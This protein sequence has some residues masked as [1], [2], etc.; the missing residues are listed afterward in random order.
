MYTTKSGS[1]SEATLLAWPLSQSN[2]ASNAGNPGSSEYKNV[3]YAE[4]YRLVYIDTD[5]NNK[6]YPI[7]DPVYTTTDNTAYNVEK[8]GVQLY[9][10]GTIYRLE[11]QKTAAT[12][13]A[14]QIAQTAP[15][16]SRIA[17]VGTADSGKIYTGSDAASAFVTDTTEVASAVDTL[18]KD[19]F[20]G[21]TIADGL[22]KAQDIFDK[23]KLNPADSRK[24][25]V[26]VFGANDTWENDNTDAT[27][28]ADATLKDK[29][30]T[31]VYTIGLFQKAPTS[32]VEQFM[33]QMSS[34]YYSTV[35]APNASYLVEDTE[36]GGKAYHYLSY[37]SVF[38][39]DA[40]SIYEVVKNVGTAVLSVTTKMHLGTSN[41]E[42][43]NAVLKDIISSNF[44]VT[45]IDYTVETAEGYYE[46]D[47]L[48][49]KEPDTLSETP[50]WDATTRTL[51]YTGFDYNANYISKERTNG[52]GQKIIVTI[53]GLK[54]KDSAA[55]KIK[56]DSDR[57]IYFNDAASGIYKTG[58]EDLVMANFPRPYVDN[59]TNLA[60]E[61]S[62]GK[63][64]NDNGVVVNK[65]LTP[66]DN[67]KYDLTVET[68]TTKSNSEYLEKVPTDFIVVADQSRSMETKDM[69]GA[70]TKA[71]TTYIETIA[72]DSKQENP[73]GYYYYDSE[74][75]TYYRVYAVKGYLYEYF[76]ANT[77]WTQN[78][79]EDAGMNLSW[80]QGKEDATY[81]VA[82]QYYY[83]TSDG[84][85]RPV[86]TSATGKVGTYYIKFSYK[87]ANGETKKFYRPSKPV[88]KN[89]FGS[90]NSKYQQGSFGYGPVNSAVL[91]AYPDTDAYTY[92]EFL[93]ITT[94]MYINYPMYKRRVGYTELR[95]RDM[96]GKEHTVPA[97]NGGKTW[98]YCNSSKQ[99][100]TTQSGSTRPIYT[101]LY[102]GSNNGS[103]LDALKEALTQF[104]QA[105]AD[106][107]DDTGSVDNRI[108]I[109]GFSSNGNNNTELLTGENLTVRNNNGTQ[110]T[111]ADA[112]PT[113]TY[114]TALVSAT[115]KDNDGKNITGQ[116]NEK[117][118]AGINALTAKGGTQPEDGLEMAYKILD[119]RSE[120]DKMHTLHNG[121]EQVERN[122]FV[123]FF[124]DGHPG[125]YPF[126]DMYTESNEVV[127][128]AKDI[129]GYRSFGDS[130]KG[131]SLFS[132]GVFGD[133]D[134]NPLTYVAHRTNSTSSTS[135]SQNFYEYEL[136]WVE[137]FDAAG[138]YDTTEKGGNRYQY[139]NRNWL[140]GNAATYGDTANDTI[141]DYM[142]VVSSNY[143]NATQFMNVKT[144]NTKGEADFSNNIYEGSYL[145]MVNAVRGDYIGSNKYYRMASNQSTL[146]QA[147]QQAVSMT[148]TPLS[149]NQ[150]LDSA[151]V[152]RDIFDDN[153]FQ[154]TDDT[155]V[156]T[157]T[158]H[159][160]MDKNG[161]VN[162]DNES[163]N[164]SLNASIGTYN[165]KTSVD[166]TGFDYIEHYINYGTGSGADRIEKQEGEKLVV[167]ITDIIPKN[168]VVSDST[169]SL[170]FSND[171]ASAMYVKDTEKVVK[172]EFPRP[173]VTRHKYTL[174]ISDA[175]KNAVFNVSVK[176][177]DADGKELDKSSDMLEDVMIVYP[178]TDRAKYS[179][180]GPQTFYGMANEQSFYIENL[181]DN[182]Q[183]Q[184][185]VTSTDD[186]YNYFIYYDGD[187]KESASPMK[188][189]EATSPKEFAYTD[190][191]IHI[192]SERGEKDISIREETIGTYADTTLEFPEVITMEIPVVSG[193]D[194][195]GPFTFDCTFDSYHNF[196]ED[197]VP[198]NANCKAVFTKV[199]EGN[200]VITAKLTGFEWTK[201]SSSGTWTL[202]DN[203]FPMQTGDEITITVKSGNT[204]KVVE[205][206]SH[207]YG[208]TYYSGQ[209]NVAPSDVTLKAANGSLL[210][211]DY[212]LTLI[213]VDGTD[214][215]R[216]TLKF[217]DGVITNEN[218][219][220]NLALYQSISCPNDLS[221]ATLDIS[222][223][224]F[225]FEYETDGENEAY[226]ATIRDITDEPPGT[227]TVIKNDMDILVVNRMGDIP[228]ESVY[229]NGHHSIIYILAGAGAL[230]LAVGGYYVWKKKDEFVED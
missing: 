48:K 46:G 100:L 224:S 88:Y 153:N 30:N 5:D 134:G 8:T 115:K 148:R 49:W 94:G 225:V 33:Q 105:V 20:N 99:A 34:E 16:G 73:E 119:N 181:P 227:A 112:S 128:K 213:P 210:T 19:N 185:V 44:T 157:A 117:L 12:S 24:R 38:P 228:I 226:V 169:N 9:E 133:S 43:D 220:I 79:I 201:G 195:K 28:L 208:V 211:G 107:T 72:S 167:T 21:T 204:I 122:M 50:D 170:I 175:N 52:N 96:S 37:G 108:A 206:N 138:Y 214:G 58:L 176:I 69:P 222:G 129:K 162:F 102:K 118:T 149:R 61:G 130:T 98:E 31:S 147:F 113:T 218:E 178:N 85:Y 110:K 56:T 137:T 59:R 80:F 164:I 29:S 35:A 168:G 166:V 154:I 45:N 182:Y 14:E 81:S 101:N 152:M 127:T 131:P 66:K 165:G 187:A 229:D 77:K 63:V 32:T 199:S 1:T 116:V 155:T 196:S 75:D 135:T 114:G 215:K 84:V 104:A 190:S 17:V 106:E 57:R 230:A 121:T 221:E 172:T 93:G 82:N 90:D 111:D 183:V 161:V 41:E 91:L 173:A 123:I 68:Y 180:V 2:S 74:A 13:L 6:A 219:P 191:I 142:S 76:A 200:G 47:E 188:K 86:S 3:L 7:G 124:T 150:A 171:E 136:G 126:S 22:N 67:G 158:V 109:V 78:I 174:D 184:T 64:P 95:Y 159:G 160:R 179:Q 65:Y 89:V 15:E 36:N 18:S 205:S 144:S 139:L 194:H 97:S 143:P 11:A 103:R 42:L 26:I 40:T 202:K 198:K 151:S 140:P 27:R 54:L 145:K 25:V 192:Y 197:T 125:D 223:E 60:P 216:K 120:A 83:K 217:K 193:E 132:I 203:E 51:T 212:E 156:K 87:D 70:Y 10:K 141:Y 92:S 209:D 23:N 207:D 39:D 189:G 71:G 4:G 163:K 146:V 177:L 55:E 62:T 53:S 186:A